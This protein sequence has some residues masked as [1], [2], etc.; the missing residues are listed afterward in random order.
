MKLLT[1]IG[2]SVR[3]A[4]NGEA[5]IRSWE[6]WNPRLILMDVHMPV[7]DGL[8]ATRRIKADK[9]GKETVIVALTASAMDE[10]RR[11]VAQSG[12]DDF[13]AKPCSEDQ[14]LET[15]RARLNIVYDYDE[16]GGNEG[17]YLAGVDALSVDGLGKLPRE[18]VEELRNAT[19]CG[20]K[21][22]L[23]RLILQVSEAEEAGCARALQALA[24]KYEYDAL[25]RLLEETYR[26]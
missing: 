18:L 8:E 11:T 26:Q 2:F 10:D 25:T 23:D 6:E 24:D 21:K 14:L 13:V 1:S 19:L 22:L 16:M 5:A 7:M 9:R 4:D 3:G 12:A 17:E 15:I 20:N